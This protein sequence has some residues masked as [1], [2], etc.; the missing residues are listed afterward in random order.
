MPLGTYMKSL[1]IHE[2]NAFAHMV[3]NF[4]LLALSALG[5]RTTYPVA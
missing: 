1:L 3:Y 4:F 2:E 5:T